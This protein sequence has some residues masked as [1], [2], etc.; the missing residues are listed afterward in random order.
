LDTQNLSEDLNKQ[1]RDWGLN[2]AFLGVGY[3]IAFDQ[4]EQIL[5][6]ILVLLKP[7]V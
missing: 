1:N 3:K 2:K 7:T 6:I 4:H 5:I